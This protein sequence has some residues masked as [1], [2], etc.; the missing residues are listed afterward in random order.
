MWEWEWDLP[1]VEVL[2]V[3]M[4]GTANANILDYRRVVFFALRMWTR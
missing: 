2:R 4:T 3:S 1:D